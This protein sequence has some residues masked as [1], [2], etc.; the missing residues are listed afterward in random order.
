MAE[1]TAGAA[2]PAAWL[3]KTRQQHRPYEDPSSLLHTAI[4]RVNWHASIG[5]TPVKPGF[6]VAR[7]ADRNVFDRSPGLLRRWRGSTIAQPGRRRGLARRSGTPRAI[8]QASTCRGSAAD[9][10]REPDR[11]GRNLGRIEN[12]ACHARHRSLGRRIGRC[13]ASRRTGHRAACPPAGVGTLFEG[14]YYVTR[15][16]HRLGLGNGLV[17]AFDAE[18]VSG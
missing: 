5:L 2:L 15:T 17:C 18:R 4:L 13:F 3:A 9:P 1:G 10:R 6:N 7:N 12:G 14:E 11:T 8:V 16:S